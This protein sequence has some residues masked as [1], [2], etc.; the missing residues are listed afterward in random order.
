MTRPTPPPLRADMDGDGELGLGD[1]GPW[2]STLWDNVQSI[3]L[4][5]GDTALVVILV[6]FPAFA[7]ARG[8]STDWYGG[9]FSGATSALAW[10]LVALA[11]YL[12]VRRA[13]RAD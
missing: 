10:L 6:E 4:L 3:F 5:P 8:M 7:R 12:T 11:I 13:R 2:L 1:V 9:W